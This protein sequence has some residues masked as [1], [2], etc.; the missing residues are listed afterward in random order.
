MIKVRK[1]LTSLKSK[2]RQKLKPHNL[3]KR[4]NKSPIKMK[5]KSKSHKQQLKINP[6]NQL[7]LK[8][9]PLKNPTIP[10]P[11]K[12]NQVQDSNQNKEETFSWTEDSIRQDKVL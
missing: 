10:K 8:L 4:K 11:Y 7:K 3:F 5:R 9:N 2:N 12:A 1:S 6:K